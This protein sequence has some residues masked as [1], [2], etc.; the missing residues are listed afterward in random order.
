[1][2]PAAGSGR[3]RP[4]RHEDCSWSAWIT[5]IESGKRMLL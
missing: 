5:T 4:P 2:K 3:D 1:L